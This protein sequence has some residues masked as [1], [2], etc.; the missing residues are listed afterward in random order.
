MMDEWQMQELMLLDAEDNEAELEALFHDAILV[1]AMAD[2]MTEEQAD[3]FLSHVGIP[4]VGNVPHSGR[5][6]WGTGENPYQ[7]MI[8]FQS[9]VRRLKKAGMSDVDIA[10]HMGLRNTAH[11]KAKSSVAKNELEKYRRDMAVK[12]KAK[13]MS[14]VAIAQ[15][16][17]GDPRK[18]TTVH[19]LLKRADEEKKNELKDTMDAI[20]GDIKK[21]HM[22]AIGEGTELYLNVTNSRMETAIEALKDEGYKVVNVRVPQ[23]QKNNGDMTVVR[24][25]T[26]HPGSDKE[27]YAY[28]HKHLDG[29]K[30]C[31]VHYEDSTDKF[32]ELEPP[33]SISSKRIKV[34]YAEDGG[35]EKD[36]T[37]EIRRG[38]PDLDLGRAHYA[39]VRIAVDGTHYLKGMCL[40]KDDMPPG[41]DV[42]F[43][44]NKH[45][46][47][48]L[49]GDKFNSVLKPMEKDPQNPFGATIRTQ[50]QLKLIQRHYIDKNGQPQ[51]SCLNIVNEE[52]NW[53]EW[54]R[55]I[56]AQMLSKQSVPLIRKHL[57]LTRQDRRE[58]FN[59]I[60]SITNPVL[61][62]IRLEEF[63]DA[64][65][66]AA[67][68]LKAHGFARQMTQVLLP[69]STLKPNEIYAPNFKDGEEVVLIRYPHASIHEIPSL[70]VNNRNKEGKSVLGRPVDGVGIPPEVAAHLSGADFDGDTAIVI[71]NNSHD[72]QHRKYFEELKGFDGKE[73]Y[74]GYPGMKRMTKKQRGM[75]MG[76]I[77]NLIT[78]M[79]AQGAPIQDMV[80]AIKHS[81]VV[82]DAYKHGLDFRRSEAENHIQQLRERYQVQPN[83]HVGG[84]TT[85]FSKA[86]SPVRIPHR[87]FKG[88]DPETGE[89]KWVDSGKINHL[90]KYKNIKNEEGKIVKREYLKDDEGNQIYEDRERTVELKRM[91]VEKDAMNLVSKWKF[92]NELA[93]ARYANDMKALGNRAR[94]EAAA[95]QLPKKDKNAAEVYKAEVKSIMGKLKQAMM[96]KPLERQASILTMA[97]IRLRKIESNYMD[98]DEEK[99]LKNRLFRENRTLVGADKN[100]IEL[101]DDEQK[102]L[103]SNALSP[104]AARQV[105]M[106]MT[107][108]YRNALFTKPKENKLTAN[109]IAKAEHMLRKGKTQGEVAAE[110]GISVDTLLDNV[111]VE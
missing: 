75:E 107:A 67:V 76:K 65:D 45:R 51:L 66:S 1:E 34:V 48:P 22:V 98:P 21:N 63:G 97:E 64:C 91:A 27:A 8:D 79:T 84:A 6:A 61:R 20:R 103:N 30:P 3:A 58:E 99:K 44:T 19:N 35:L 85:L 88:Y 111:V 80:P 41:V 46:G 14:N 104:T 56:S 100:Y 57:D 96:N 68:H 81:M 15:R 26:D 2:G 70:I 5:Y 59:E 74:K 38:C 52:G 12:L 90:P 32:H 71:P 39:Q 28:V 4:H 18:D 106:N 83:G 7:G 37:I 23:Y 87:L 13:G 105:F 54:N 43:N 9:T 29:I 78:D 47:T 10:K 86:G 40:Y 24:V 101:T 55:T 82:I 62:K 25:L 72:I 50:S 109:Q 31:G 53:R 17:F 49:M 16:M 92:S 110:L 102:A 60:M 36:G 11:L 73:E 42:I 89:K 69:L 33:R 108:P 94:K 93:Y 95:I 77:T